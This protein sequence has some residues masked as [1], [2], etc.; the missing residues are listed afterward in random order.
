MSNTDSTYN[1]ALISELGVKRYLKGRSDL[2][3]SNIDFFIRG[4]AA[5]SAWKECNFGCHGPTY[6]TLTKPSTFH[7]ALQP[8]D[9][10]SPTLAGVIDGIRH[11]TVGR[12]QTITDGIERTGEGLMLNGDEAFQNVGDE[13]LA[14][15]QFATT[16]FE[17]LVTFD[18]D[19]LENPLS[20]AVLTIVNEYTA[21]IP[22]WVLRNAYQDG[23]FILP[24]SINAVSLMKAVSMGIIKDIDQNDVNEAIDLLS[25]PSKRFIG[26][27]IGKKLAS[28]M[29][30]VLA[31]SI[32]KKL[33]NQGPGINATKRD[34]AK[35]RT[36]MRGLKGGLAGT[37]LTLL[38][39]QGF[40]DR[41]G[42]ASR[43]LNQASPRVWR[44]LRY[45]LNGA[46]MVYFLVEPFLREYVDRLS[47]LERRP[48]EF[49]KVMA[50]LV[51]AK[52][53]RNIFF[54]GSSM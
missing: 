50:A 20:Q 25:N 47:L 28:A 27:Q 54:P 38:Q 12:A 22:E 39:A 31:A 16:C 30:A 14:A 51:Q 23:A 6:R 35:L 9:G 26:K 13:N 34:L 36:H 5:E 17:K 29:G 18:I 21:V 32:S 53:T 11:Q 40:L 4:K 7:E 8:I 43:R 49:A 52:Q 1:G 37:L 45:E 24:D 44:L 42:D 19:T 48:Q 10:L 33:L 2:P 46:N 41:A 3:T 15:Y